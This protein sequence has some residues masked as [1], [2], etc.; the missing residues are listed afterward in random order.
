VGL[1]SA[2]MVI[3]NLPGNLIG[4]AL[5][6]RHFDR[7]KLIMVASAVTSLLSLAAYLDLLPDLPRYLCCVMLSFCG[8][9]PCS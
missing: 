4:G 5:I 8:A 7:G 9:I 2:L 1:L 3:V 6:Q